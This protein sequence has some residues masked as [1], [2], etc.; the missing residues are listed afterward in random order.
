MGTN[1]SNCQNSAWTAEL[2]VVLRRGVD[3][4]LESVTC[5]RSGVFER[6]CQK[7]RKISVGRTVEATENYTCKINRNRFLKKSRCT[8]CVTLSHNILLRLLPGYGPMDLDRKQGCG[9]NRGDRIKVA[10]QNWA[11][12]TRC[13]WFL[14]TMNDGEV[15]CG[16]SIISY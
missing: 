3:Y 13:C 15:Y 7:R 9:E 12:R 8:C 11:G 16:V 1:S 14:C 4:L 2:M 10:Y 6:R 5:E